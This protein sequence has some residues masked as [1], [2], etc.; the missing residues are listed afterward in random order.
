M[1][2]R[3][4]RQSENGKGA[5]THTTDAHE[6]DKDFLSESEID[7]L[8]NAAKKGRHGVRDHLLMLMMYRH[9]L[10]VGEAVRLRQDDLNLQ[11]VRMWV[12][13]SKNGLSVEHPIAGDEL[14]AIKRYLATRED[15]L[16]WLF[17][18]ERGTQLTERAV[19]DLLR[20]AGETAGLPQ[21]PP[22][23]P[24]AFL[25]LLSRRPRHRSADHAGLPRPPRSAPHGPLYAGRGT[26][27]RGALEVRRE[28]PRAATG[29][30]NSYF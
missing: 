15:R 30:G 8:L 23:H 28:R 29:G 26:A 27:V 16:P 5:N 14:R 25:R 4:N 22:A 17:I 3:R 18:S 20:R 19:H 13:R 24:A 2:K 7:L 9:G 11:Q 6:R 21:V 12:R 1:A 10:R